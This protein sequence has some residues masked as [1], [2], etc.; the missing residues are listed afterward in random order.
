MGYAKIQA[1][2]KELEE[3]V[4]VKCAFKDAAEKL[5]EVARII[6]KAKQEVTQRISGLKTGGISELDAYKENL[7]LFVHK[8]EAARAPSLQP[9]V[10]LVYEAEEELN[11]MV[12]AYEDKLAAN[13]PKDVKPGM[14]FKD[15]SQQRIFEV[16]T[17]PTKATNINLRGDSALWF[18]VDIFKDGVKSGSVDLN[19][20]DLKKMKYLRT[21]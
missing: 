17:G 1:K 19:S 15:P 6:E 8:L 20:A 4:E 11:K 13:C 16:K 14:T 18:E 9:I 21:V 10:K 2:R 5:N 7:E 12:R 3:K